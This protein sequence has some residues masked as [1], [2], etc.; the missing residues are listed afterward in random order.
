M[1][2]HKE[3]QDEESNEQETKVNEKV[4][5]IFADMQGHQKSEYVTYARL[6][7]LLNKLVQE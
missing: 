5:A 6:E 4:A 1:A 2:R 7:E 3:S